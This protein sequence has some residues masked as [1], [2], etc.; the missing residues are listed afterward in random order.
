MSQQLGQTAVEA[1]L[2]RVGELQARGGDFVTERQTESIVLYHKIRNCII[3]C[4][5][6]MARL[7]KVHAMNSTV[8][9]GSPPAA[10]NIAVAML[11]SLM[12]TH[13]SGQV[14]MMEKSKF[15]FYFLTTILEFM[16]QTRLGPRPRAVLQEPVLLRALQGLLGEEETNK[17]LVLARHHQPGAEKVEPGVGQEAVRLAARPE[18][19]KG[20]V[21]A[22]PAPAREVRRQ[23]LV[24]ECG[25]G[26]GGR[27][28]GGPQGAPAPPEGRHPPAGGGAEGRRGAGRPVPG[29]GLRPQVPG[30][31]VPAG[32]P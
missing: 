12:A 23:K 13:Y 14:L 8:Q 15:D 25:D 17:Q 3:D 32:A 11:E 30:P 28:A 6:L 7:G 21:Q 2:R 27:T 5:N 29:Q 4:H 24:A 22:V 9:L 20:E 31:R 1:F 26:G 18:E 10:F 19:P 16:Q